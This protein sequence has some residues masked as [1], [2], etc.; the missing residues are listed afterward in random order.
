MSRSIRHLSSKRV[1]F[2]PQVQHSLIE[3]VCHA[4]EQ[5]DMVRAI[6]RETNGQSCTVSVTPRAHRPRVEVLP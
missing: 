6:W 4:V 5:D 1:I 2:S 3:V